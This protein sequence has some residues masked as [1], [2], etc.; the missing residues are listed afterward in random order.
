[1]EVSTELVSPNSI[2]RKL[3]LHTCLNVCKLAALHGVD[4]SSEA[5][6][7]AIADLKRRGPNPFL[8]VAVAATWRSF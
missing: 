1:M 7:A 4:A 8:P 5:L 6:T 2:L 3:H